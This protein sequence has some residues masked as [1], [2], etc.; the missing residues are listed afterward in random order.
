MTALKTGSQ[1]KVI[2][3]PGSYIVN[4][5]T[6]AMRLTPET[7]LERLVWLHRGEKVTMKR[8]LPVKSLNALK[9]HGLLKLGDLEG[10]KISTLMVIPRIGAG[11][12]QQIADAARAAG[13]EVADDALGSNTLVVY[14]RGPL[15]EVAR[16]IVGN[17][18]EINP[19]DLLRRAMADLQPEIIE[20]M[21][22]YTE[23]VRRQDAERIREQ[24]EY[25]Q[26]QLQKILN[27][28]MFVLEQLAKGK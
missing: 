2:S 22:E 4:D 27:P 21:K 28:E 15:A 19:A 5:P 24:M 18:T 8:H 11:R 17:Y 13:V 7:P 26:M 1:K 25:L 9:Q 16:Q 6:D 23:D 3:V 14:V 20:K 10:V 12:A